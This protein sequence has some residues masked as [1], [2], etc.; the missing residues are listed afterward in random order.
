MRLGLHV[1]GYRNSSAE[2]A[3]ETV[4]FGARCLGVV[5]VRELSPRSIMRDEGFRATENWSCTP[6]VAVH[7]RRSHR[8][9]TSSVVGETARSGW[10]PSRRPVRLGRK[11]PCGA[12]GLGP[13]HRQSVAGW[14]VPRVRSEIPR[15]GVTPQFAIILCVRADVAKLTDA[16]DLGS[17]PRNRVWVQV[18]PSVPM[19]YGEF[20][21]TANGHRWTLAMAVFSS[22][23]M[24]VE[25]ST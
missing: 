15:P 11:S 6:R 19:T 23:R 20:Q 21:E 16:L 1:R 17:S 10:V 12:P 5:H 13:A 9:T 4:R 18:P 2:F 25:S 3:L 14:R 24:R 22:G 7:G 8:R